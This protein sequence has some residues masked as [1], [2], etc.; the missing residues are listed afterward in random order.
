MQSIRIGCIGFAAA[1][2]ACGSAEPT[3]QS[4]VF[5]ESISVVDVQD[6]VVRPAMDVW[7][8][9][10]RIRAVRPTGDLAAPDGARL[11]D[12]RGRFLM[13]GMWDM[14]FHAFNQVSGRSPS[15]WAFPVTVAHGVTAVREMWTKPEDMDQVRSWRAAFAGGT[16]MPRIALAG[17]MVD[18]DPPAFSN[19]VVVRDSAEAVAAVREIID[20]GTDFVKAYSM[21]S[22]GAFAVLVREAERQGI[23]VA[24]HVPI[25][26]D[27][28]AAA[29]AGMASHEH[30]NELIETTC[31]TRTEELRAV[32]WDDWSMEHLQLALDTYDEGRCQAV[33]DVLAETGTVQ[34][35]TLVNDWMRQLSPAQ[36]DARFE[37]PWVAGMP[38]GDRAAWEE[39][40]EDRAGWSEADWAANRGIYEAHVM[41]V[42][43]LSEAGV[44][45]MTGTDFSNPFL[46][47]GG[48]VLEEL[49]LLVNAGLTPAA[50]LRA[51]TIVPAR[52]AS[53]IDSL[54][55]IDDG[56]VADLVILGADPLADIRN[57]RTAEEVILNGQLLDVDQLLGLDSGP[58]SR[59]P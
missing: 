18:G 48:S 29:R 30:L 10:N 38:A 34:V 56:M 16:V 49:E 31:S 22:P 43:L 57:V 47:P 39:A 36:L 59:D 46:Y 8:E 44:P 40:R 4:H 25:A 51:A 19:A 17:T 14:H 52:F 41:L 55:T 53:A 2:S 3:A 23:P 54:G 24:G 37:E 58:S 42:E 21:L 33:I 6:G 35:P 27:V 5:V 45:I 1:L 15:E 7:V 9:G 32:S 20:S 50:A 28:E 12:G 13:P 26:V 11:V